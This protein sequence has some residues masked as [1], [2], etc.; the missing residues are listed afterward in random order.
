MNRL[1]PNGNGV[2]Q[3]WRNGMCHYSAGCERLLLCA[4]P[5]FR[6]ES[7]LVAQQSFNNRGLSGS[8]Q[9]EAAV[10]VLAPD[11]RFGR[12]QTLNAPRQIV[13]PQRV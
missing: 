11:D 10:R 8:N 4:E 2:L 7:A 1:N 13:P 6:P 3:T 9:P 12:L 5:P